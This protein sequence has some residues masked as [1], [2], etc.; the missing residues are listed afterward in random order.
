[1]EIF[2]RKP[3]LRR[4]PVTVV[5]PEPNLRA[6]RYLKVIRQTT[7]KNMVV[8]SLFGLMVIGAAAFG[9][10]IG[11]LLVYSTD[12]PQVSDLEHYR[13]SAVTELYDD[14]G[15]VVASFALQRRIIASYEEIPQVLKDA[16]LSIEDRDF[17]S[18][19]GVD[20]RRVVGALYRD[21]AGVGVH[22]GASTLTMQLSRKLFLS[23]E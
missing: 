6:W 7:E 5:P 12:L 11:L 8:R 1:M 18:H 21:L 22:Q 15:R 13:P 3:K 14:Q 19:W 4:K 10:F 17:E 16:V 20:V 9:A 23:D 2:R